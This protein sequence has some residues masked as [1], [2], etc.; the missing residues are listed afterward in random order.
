M[1]SSSAAVTSRWAADWVA[2][3]SGTRDGTPELRTAARISTITHHTSCSQASQSTIDSTRR[4]DGMPSWWVSTDTP[5]V[6]CGHGSPITPTSA[7]GTPTVSAARATTAARPTSTSPAVRCGTCTGC[8]SPGIGGAI[9]TL[10]AGLR[11]RI[12]S[13][14]CRWR[15]R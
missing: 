6:P 7:I 4:I 15:S 9:S 5:T 3:A 14:R 8:L 1:N 12:R 13:W 10:L 2:P 11:Y